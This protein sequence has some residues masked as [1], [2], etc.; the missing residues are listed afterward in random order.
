MI[1][2]GFATCPQCGY[3]FPPPERQKHEAK[4][5]EAGILTGQVTDTKY[6]VMD[7]AYSVHTKRDAPPD[8][9]KT[10]RVDYRLGL[11]HWQSEFICVEHDGYARQKAE[12]WWQRRS[13]DPIPDTA[14]RAVEIAEAGG[15]CP[16]HGITV[17]TVTGERFDRIVG[18]DLGPRP[19]AVPV[20]DVFADE[21]VPF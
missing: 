1:A 14:E 19:D 16:T 4:A 2:A 10:M 11:S 9:P 20:G 21:E 17:R 13:P 7:I 8:A 12:S 3:E 5:T 6:E 15:L 18:Y